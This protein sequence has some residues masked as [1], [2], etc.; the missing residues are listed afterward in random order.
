MKHTQL[1]LKTKLRSLTAAQSKLK[2]QRLNQE[3]V[4]NKLSGMQ[5]QKVGK[6]KILRDTEDT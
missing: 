4:Q 6:Y 2:R 3:I 5:K 1:K